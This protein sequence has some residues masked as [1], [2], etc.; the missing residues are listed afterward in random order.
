MLAPLVAARSTQP[1]RPVAALTN[2]F[3]AAQFDGRGLTSLA[4]HESTR[5]VRFVHDGFALKIGGRTIDSADLPVPRRETISGALVVFTWTAPSG[6][7]RVEYELQ[8]S[9]HFVS[10]RLVFTPSSAHAFHVDD[11]DVLQDTL[12][13]APHDVFVPKSPR[14]S[15]GTGDYGA[16]LRFVDG[17]GL[18]AIGQNPFLTF[19][20]EGARFSLA[21][22]PDMDWAAAD[23]P[24]ESDRALLI[25]YRQDPAHVLPAKMQPEWTLDATSGEPGL[26]RPEIAAFT[27]A[28]RAFLLDPRKTPLDVMVGWCAND[29]Q[30]DV[31]RPEGRT[32][33]KRLI[34]RAA[35]LGAQYVLYAPSNS[36][37]SRRED[38]IDDWSWEHVLWLGL[39]Q[40]IRKGEWDPRTSAVPSSVREMIDYA[41]SKHVKLL[42]YVYPVLPFAGH[43]D[44][45][46]TAPNGHRYSNLGFRDFQNWLVDELVAFHDR[47]GIGGYA[48]DHTFLTY[49]GAS[50]YA[51]WYGW[52]RVMA[53]LRT[54]LPGIAIDG[55]QAY[56]L[57][58]PWTW[59]AGSY[60]HPTSTDEQ[61][62]SFVP[63]PDL[64]VDRVAADRE[65]F[66]AFWYRNYQFA[67]SRILPGF[68]THQ[69]SRSDDTGDMPQMKTPDRGTVLLPFRRRDWD[70]LGWRYSLL[71]SI[72]V[73]GL[74]NVIDMI[75][76]RD[77]AEFRH[78]SD[79]DI[80]WFRHWIDWTA[81]NRR[82]L[83][84]TRTILGQ[85]AIGKL[86][87]TSAIDGDSGY[88]F[89]FNPNG[90]RM[91]AALPLDAT[92]GL[93]GGRGTYTLREIYP[94]EGRLLAADDGTRPHD[95][96]PVHVEIDGG[97]ALVLR[98]D[99]A[100][101]AI[102]APVLLGVR[103]SA[104]MSGTTVALSEVRGLAGT[105]AEA[106]ILLPAGLHPAA[107]RVNGVR[108]DFERPTPGHVRLRLHFAG[109]PFRKMQPA[110]E[111]PSDFHGGVIS[112]T[113]TIPRR[114]FDQLAARRRAWPIPWTADDLRTP[115]LASERLLLFVQIA[116]PK[117]AWTASLAVDG[118]AMPLIKAY[119]A[120][121]PEPSTFVGFYADLSALAPDRPHRLDVRL[122]R[123][124]RGQLQ[125]VFFE[126]VEPEYTAQLAPGLKTRP[127][128][129]SPARSR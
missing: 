60:P 98:I 67:P 33:Y 9:W 85:P 78:F 11:V 64:H 84:H 15:L 112:G 77:E 34:D 128:T 82:F 10:K 48:F 74:N 127:T 41:R 65:R 72:A 63:F 104:R 69:T 13:E 86:D 53:R 46:V 28:V 38:S 73:A 91:T 109:V 90:R 71:S 50:R 26:Q 121:R 107:A 100:P 3:V 89:L 76:A 30:I 6:T 94:D 124:A 12:D 88:V 93:A 35:A 95:G 61:P 32:E 20:R 49:P 92:I 79:A 51:Q 57:Y 101:A 22:A 96:V 52:R 99:P 68:I 83:R 123:L 37:L 14:P 47:T 36:A 5:P 108:V 4:L 18:L 17:R 8:P 44:W 122:P 43:P 116:E 118:R 75:P 25:P 55:R 126:N 117:A 105:D 39:G 24:F 19:T 31:A 111:V 29:Y 23:G 2:P 102:T 115:W 56:Q 42:A 110:M 125:G 54:R 40:R 70:Y 119:S 114:I 106:D 120:V 103:G 66:T 27:D 81:E 129:G 45:L 16:A 59:L 87:G 62:E 80:A 7:I 58:G 1:P 21:Y 113:V 97:S